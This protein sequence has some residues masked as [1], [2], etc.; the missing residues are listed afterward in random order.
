VA[1]IAVMFQ[2]GK[3]QTRVLAELKPST[4]GIRQLSETAIRNRKTV[5]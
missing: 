2:S 3:G 4:V 5:L 1:T